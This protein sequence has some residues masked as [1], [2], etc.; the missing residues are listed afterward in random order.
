[1]KSGYHH[2]VPMADYLSDPCQEPSLSTSTVAL[3]VNKTPKMAHLYH[4]RL[5]GK[6]N[7][8]SNRGDIGS[9]VH[10]LVL[11]GP[12][13]VYCGEVE[14]RS[15]KRKG[16]KFSAEDWATSD[17][18]AFRDEA[19]KSGSIPLLETQ[20]E[21]VERA[22]S[23]AIE[24]LKSLGEGTPEA[25]MIWQLT[26]GVWCRGRA[27]WLTEFRDIDL[28]TCD[29]ADAHEWARRSIRSCN[30]D[31]QAGLRNIGHLILGEQRNQFW[32]L[33]EITEP[34]DC[35]LVGVGGT[36]LELA[37]RKVMY[38]ADKWKKCLSDNSFPGYSK[39]PTWI[40]STMY[41]SVDAEKRGI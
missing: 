6:S 41:D 3:L 15:G 18:K 29:D 20:R 9:A 36:M 39:Y 33:Q 30:L 28:K 38:A 10:S 31:I 8:S 1:M 32:L 2:G 13:V 34:Y 4:P 17:A 5:G 23:S 16:E 27:D 25:T 40:D 24:L 14:L 26:N 19:R 11:G 35:S 22:A 21:V 37:V 7:E 12:G